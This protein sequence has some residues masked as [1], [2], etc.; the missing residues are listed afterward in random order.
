MSTGCSTDG[1][2]PI[3]LVDDWRTRVTDATVDEEITSY[4]AVPATGVPGVSADPVAVAVTTVDAAEASVPL[5]RRTP[6]DDR[7][8]IGLCIYSE[9]L[10]RHSDFSIA[11]VRVIGPEP[12]LIPRCTI[13]RSIRWR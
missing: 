9:V 11:T 8:V 6:A 3:E 1:R 5:Q 7:S 12:I 13:I 10:S 4:R 2:R